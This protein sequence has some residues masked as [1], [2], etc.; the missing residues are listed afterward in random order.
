MGTILSSRI[1]EDGK[2]VFEVMVDYE[3]SVQLKGHMDNIHVF[4]ENVA[5]IKTTISQRG[6]N[7]ATKYFL[8]PRELRQDMKFN[9]PTKC[10]KIETKTKT[11]FIYT[12]DKLG[13]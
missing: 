7:E 8:I 1:K 2:V 9:A 3:E 10:Q 13:L 5:D 6:K 11:I 12:I 4:S